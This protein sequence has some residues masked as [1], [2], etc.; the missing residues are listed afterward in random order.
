MK[1]I[2]CE[3]NVLENVSMK[4]FVQEL[5]AISD[6]ISLK[7]DKKGIVVF[8]NVEEI[9][10]NDIVTL[11]YKFC[12][13]ASVKIESA[14]KSSK[15]IIPGVSVNFANPYVERC[16]NKLLRTAYAAIYKMNISEEWVG[17]YI[18][19]TTSNIYYSYLEPKVVRVSV[20]DIVECDFGYTI[21]G[22]TNGTRI[23]A[24]VCN[25][26]HNQ[27]M[28]YVVPLVRIKKGKD[29][30]A[31]SYVV[32]KVNKDA[33][34]KDKNRQEMVAILNQ[35]KEIRVERVSAFVGKVTYYF[36]EKVLKQLP[37]AFDFTS[38][39]KSYSVESFTAN[40]KTE[41]DDTEKIVYLAY[42]ELTTSKGSNSVNPTESTG[43][44]ATAREVVVDE[45]K[46]EKSN[47][48][49]NEKATSKVGKHEAILMEFFGED[50]KTI[51]TTD[52]LSRQAST[53]MGIIGMCWTA[54]MQDIFENAFDVNINSYA[55]ICG[56]LR[57]MEDAFGLTAK[58]SEILAK[59]YFQEW[60]SK[61]P[62]IK[63]K[64]PNISLISLLKVFV[65]C[66]KKNNI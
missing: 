11:A 46:P 32:C 29:I 21:P 17:R 20:G 27:K 36:M 38:N 44:E 9:N 30:R 39:L 3:G 33:I 26:S 64:C 12:D 47:T 4:I 62:Q 35:G 23:T 25:V 8:E 49:E 2:I 18:A 19:T 28:I 13:V 54:V 5:H 66:A 56:N 16:F 57:V 61:Y 31:T 37:T 40:M 60:L 52:P 41:E 7:C 10:I 14:E 1:N 55:S 22:E 42:P 63:E 65:K 53:F 43:Q 50:F 51:D 15:E 6:R 48:S 34:Y 24:I 45:K 58:E 59:K